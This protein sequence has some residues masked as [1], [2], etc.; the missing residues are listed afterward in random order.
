[1]GLA[2]GSQPIPIPLSKSYSYQSNV[3]YEKPFSR[4]DKKS[5]AN[6]VILQDLW[7][8]S[9][10]MGITNELQKLLAVER[11]IELQIEARRKSK[12]ASRALKRFDNERQ[13]KYYEEMYSYW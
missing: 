11:E 5:F 13:K 6:P 12:Q 8:G 4:S 9:R 1:M 10:F 3:V 2:F 7:K